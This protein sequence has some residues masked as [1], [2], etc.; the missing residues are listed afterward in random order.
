MST[1]RLLKAALASLEGNAEQILAA[2]IK[3]HC[4]VLAG[5][6]SGKTKTLTT[7]MSRTLAEDVPSPRGVACITFNNECAYELE[8]RLAELGIER[9]ERVFIGT[10]HSFALTQIIL[11]YGPCVLPSW[12]SDLTVASK[13]EQEA[14]VAAAHAD[15]IG[16]NENPH[17]RWKF[18]TEKRKYVVDRTHPD[19]RGKSEELADFIEAYEAELRRRHQIDF[20]DM[21]LIAYDMVARH[22]WIRDTI[23]A[24]YPVLFVDEYQDLGHALHKLVLKLCFESG[25]RLFAV[26]DADQSIYGFNG[27]DPSLLAGLSERKDVTAIRLRFNYR[28]GTRIINASMAALGEERGYIGPKGAHQGLIEFHPVKGGGRAQAAYVLNTLVP[29]LQEQGISLNEI[30]ILYRWAKHSKDVVALA[31]AQGM[32]F[33]RADNQALIKRS[34]AVSRFVEKCARWVIG[35]WKSAEPRFLHL[36]RDAVS[37]V[38]GASASRKEQMELERELIAF[39]KPVQPNQSAHHWLAR[40]RDDVISK[41]RLRARTLAEQ[42]EDLDE[43]IARTDPLKRDVEFTMAVFCGDTSGSGALNL[44]TF[45]SSKGREFR[46]VILLGMD[47]DVIPNKYSLNNARKLRED[48]REFYVAVTRAKEQLHVVYTDGHHSQFVA[49]LYRRSIQ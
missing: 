35:G 16:G 9:G 28:C 23:R 14:I 11:P 8:E 18:A 41:W 13:A 4:V 17:E 15:T 40:L 30:G 34:S 31:E 49:E 26:G 32:P 27:A 22:A 1:R 37:H 43:M 39:L 24:K 44:S 2:H 48:R 46:A 47:S 21:P 45:H 7:A 19:W 42:W 6:G 38:Y 36:H 25:I 5:P 3:D 29:K 33:V 10:V 20:D 12:I